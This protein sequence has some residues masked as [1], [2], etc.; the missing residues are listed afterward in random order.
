[1]NVE[2]ILYKLSLLSSRQLS[3]KFSLLNFHATLVL[4]CPGHESEENSHSNS[5]LS[6][7]IN[8]H[9]RFVSFHLGSRRV[10]DW[11]LLQNPEKSK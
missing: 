11:V 2:K 7:L 3:Y 5:R 6:T 9:A 10:L 4:V 1:M 8:S